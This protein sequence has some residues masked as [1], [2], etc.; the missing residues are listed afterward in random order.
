MGELSTFQ[1]RGQGTIAERQTT[2]AAANCDRFRT[3]LVERPRYYVVRRIV[4]ISPCRDDDAIAREVALVQLRR[5]G[6]RANCSVRV[7][8]H[9]KVASDSAAAPAL[10]ASCG[11]QAQR[12]SQ[13]PS[14]PRH[15]SSGF[16]SAHSGPSPLAHSY[17]LRRVG[18]DRWSRF[19]SHV[20]FALA[21]LRSVHRACSGRVLFS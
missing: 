11:M 12:H 6:L 3:N 14:R 2:A 10:P 19:R 15:L 17:P 20:P 1:L 8:I 9:L 16:R 7:L 13:P 18:R 5:P 21:R 4:C